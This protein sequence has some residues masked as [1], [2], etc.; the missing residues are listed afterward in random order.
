MI[1]LFGILS[2]AKVPGSVP[3][4]SGV[5]PPYAGEPMAYFSAADKLPFVAEMSAWKTDLFFQ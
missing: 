4:L 1:G 3:A 5:I 2:E